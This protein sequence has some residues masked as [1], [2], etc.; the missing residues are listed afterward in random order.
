MVRKL[1]VF[2]VA[3]MIALL[4]NVAPAMAL[5]SDPG[6]GGDNPLHSTVVSNNPL[7]VDSGNSGTNPLHTGG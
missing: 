6:K 4:M 5:F 3:I 7:Y 2:L 1:I